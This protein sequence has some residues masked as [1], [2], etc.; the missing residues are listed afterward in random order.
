MD[1]IFV[2]DNLIDGVL[3]SI[4]V[5]ADDHFLCHKLPVLELRMLIRIEALVVV[6]VGKSDVERVNSLMDSDL[7][8]FFIDGL[9]KLL[10]LTL[11]LLIVLVFNM[12]KKSLLALGTD[13][14]VLTTK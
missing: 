1:L 12:V 6:K 13:E 14:L 9:D 2:I 10:D 5:S 11:D 7:V 4:F 8:F 3:H